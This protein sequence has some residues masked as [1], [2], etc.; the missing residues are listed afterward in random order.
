MPKI[1]KMKKNVSVLLFFSF[2]LLVFA[3]KEDNLN[4]QTD[5]KKIKTQPN[6]VAS[7][8]INVPANLQYYYQNLD[9][10]K[11]GTEFYEDLAT[12]TIAKHTRFLQYSERHPYLGKADAT[13]GNTSNISLIYTGNSVSKS[14]INGS[15]NTEHIYPRSLLN[16]RLGIAD[17]HHLR[18]CD[19][20]VNNDRGNRPFTDGSGAYGISGANWYPGDEWKGDIA[21]MILYLNLRYNETFNKV[22]TNGVELFLKW[23][24]EDSVSD[25]EKQ[26]NNEI[27]TA[28]GNRNPF[29][30][31]PY[32]A[33]KI[34]GETPAQNT[35][36]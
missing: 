20:N 19:A 23:N 8:S 35:W 10:S 12:L 30:D 31:N 24:A 11:N 33:T 2:L 16:E 29:I 25:F 26:R 27:E 15:V 22:S 3:C 28:Q 36:K 4:A 6:P 1:Q 32:L 17:L 18:Y 21:R 9:F 5:S 34:W 14:H 7:Q 13:L